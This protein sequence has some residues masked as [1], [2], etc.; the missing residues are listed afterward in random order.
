[1]FND[2]MSEA[3]RTI[4]K[5]I[6]DVTEQFQSGHAVEDAYRPALR[7]LMAS[8]EDT[9]AVNDPKHSEHGAPD[10]VF[11][12]KSNTAVIKGY[13][14]AKDIGTKLDPVEKTDQLKRYAGYT[15][16]VLTDYLEFRFY[17][18]GDRYQTIR[19]GQ[20]KHGALRF[21]MSEGERLWRELRAFL[22]LPPEE[23]RSGRRL[24]QVMGAKAR[25]IKDNVEVYI[26]TDTDEARDLDRIYT[27]M[28]TLLIHDLSEEQFSD[29]YAQTL[30][31]GLFVARY[32]DDSPG[33]FSRAEARDLVPKSNPFLRQFFDHI[34]GTQFDE[35]LAKIVDELCDVF[36]V[37]KVD[38]IVHRHLRVQDKTEGIKDPIIHFYEDFLSAYDPKIRKAMGAY[39][40][41]VPV[42][43]YIVRSI[44]EILRNDL[45]IPRGLADTGMVDFEIAAQP[46]KNTKSTTI[47]KSGPKVQ[48]LDPAV[49]TATF[50]N[51]T[52]KFIRETFTGQ[53]GR[54][55]SYAE[56]QLLP[57]I[58]GF[59]LMMAPYTIAH[60]KL[61]MT[62]AE[63]GARELNERLNIYLT[64]TLEEG[65]PTQPD[66]F[67][68]GLSDTV[69]EESRLAAAVKNEQPVM[70]IMGNPPWKGES[71]NK[72]AFATGLVKKYKVEPGGK[73]KLQERNSKWINDDYVKFLS[74]AESMIAKNGKG[75]VGMITNN[76]YIDNPTFRGMRWHIAR[77]FDTLFILDLHGSLKKQ[78]KAEDGSRDENVFNIEQGAAII[79]AVKTSSST[80]PANVYQADLYGRREEKFDRLNSGRFTWREVDLD[81]S[82]YKF[83]PE[84]N[85]AL[86]KK[87]NSGVAINELFNA[88]T[89]GF[90]THR[91]HFAIARDRDE[92]L[93]RMN[94]FADPSI[95][96]ID[97]A[98]NFDLKDSSGWNVSDARA[99][100]LG[101]KFTER[102]VQLVQYRLGD[103]RWTYFDKSVSDRPR[104]LFI[105][106]VAGRDNLV[107]GVGRQGLAVGNIE[108]SLVT[109]SR[110]PMDANI[111]RR[112]G[113]NAFPLY[114]YGDDG[115]RSVN[116]NDNR[117]ADLFR[118]ISYSP[119]PEETFAY[120]YAILHS[121][122]YRQSYHDYLQD[123]FPRIPCPA[124]KEQFE[125]YV[126]VGNRLLALHL[127]ESPELDTTTITY[128]SAGDDLVVLP[129]FEAE[130][131]WINDQQY[132]GNVTQAVWDFTAGGNQVVQQW[133]KNRKGERLVSSELDHFQRIIACIEETERSVAELD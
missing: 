126:R 62:L 87:F 52:I 78:D 112:G 83:R 24:A 94:Q 58:F 60:L 125:R 25:R 106:H 43:K 70:V 132:F 2:S 71:N 16:L 9:T 84:A 10:F 48:I 95:S 75:V 55:P 30:V 113:V 99:K 49:G 61:G 5:Y 53:E 103:Q 79:L 115:S 91:D 101:Y 86:R 124:D 77:T 56:E 72:T 120:V 21:S 66:L 4:Q 97:I 38:D 3:L 121:T 65:V 93:R 96:N 122:V 11:L 59:E 57:R 81:K 22:E 80:R 26:K 69:S 54:W 90:Q 88:N 31:Y 76:G 51:E 123:G 109:V 8:F 6:N 45:N 27:L 74:F 105:K 92:I 44:D 1:M 119:S 34:A 104:S 47:T 102:D 127:Y 42:V 108:W 89:L 67:S 68:F 133:L 130:K 50:L 40:T 128:P 107:L 20:I 36:I 13:A 82:T 63:T 37:S 35:R 98:N 131:I 41:P 85:P 17:K 117:K 12:K 32:R 110:H 111:F 100:V 114:L 23:I 7:D 64:N 39:Y 116:I 14:E 18:N 19:I 73:S 15:N 33:S 28:K 46:G 129:R 118:T 29:M